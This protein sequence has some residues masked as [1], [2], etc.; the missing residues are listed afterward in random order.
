M[1]IYMCFSRVSHALSHF[2]LTPKVVFITVISQVQKSK[3]QSNWIV[4][5]TTW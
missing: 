3:C 2:I 5:G 1:Y 4:Q